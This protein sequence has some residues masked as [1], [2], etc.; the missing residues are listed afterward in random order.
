[1]AQ[2]KHPRGFSWP[3]TAEWLAEANRLM[4]EKEISQA[5]VARATG[6][7]TAA[8]A[9]LFTGQSKSSRLLP[10]ISE[11]LGIELK[12]LEPQ[13]R[14]EAMRA[15]SALWNDLTKEQQDILVSM[16]QNLAKKK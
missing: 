10:K 5:D 8:I 13:T 4:R 9:M 14:S 11:F 16:A 15:I 7:S 1:M 2:Q 3:V 6:A 12:P